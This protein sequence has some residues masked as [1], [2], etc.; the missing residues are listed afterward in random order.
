MAPAEHERALRTLRILL[1]LAIPLSVIHYTD[2]YLA[3]DLY[4]AAKIFGIELGPDTIWVSWII[5]TAAG[6]AGYWLYAR[7]RIAAAGAALA[8]YSISGLISIGHYL[9]P[10]MS[11]LE[12][13]RHAS[14]WVDITL[15][16]AVFAFAIW[17]A[18]AGR[19]RL[20]TQ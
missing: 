16:A 1:A 5:F 7:G 13:W 14:V 19:R 12:W 15:G 2:N 3:F 4:P 6:L 8:F 9:A 11:K 18:Q 20:A 17:S 10:G